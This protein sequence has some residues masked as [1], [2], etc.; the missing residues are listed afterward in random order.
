MQKGGVTMEKQ[1][2]VP[3]IIIGLV[4]TLFFLMG[5]FFAYQWWFVEKPLQKSLDQVQGLEVKELKVTPNAVVLELDIDPGRYSVPDDFPPL[6][7]KIS[8]IAGNRLLKVSFSERKTPAMDRAW[9]EMMFG[10]QEGLTQGAYTRIPQTVNRVAE[11][12][13][14]E[15][16]TSMDEQ[17]VYIQLTQGKHVLVQQLPIIKNEGEVK[18]NG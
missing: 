14:L 1:K 3:G 12:Y 8:T 5:G 18:T 13:G 9:R 15:S 6:S 16:R 17:Y 11:R 10:V 2:Q 4:V 7:Q